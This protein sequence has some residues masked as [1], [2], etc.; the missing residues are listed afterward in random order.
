[1][2]DFNFFEP[3]IDKPSRGQSSNLVWLILFVVIFAVMGFLQFSYMTSKNALEDETATIREYTQSEMILNKVAVVNEKKA[4]RDVMGTV[5]NEL[6]LFDFLMYVKSRLHV[7][8]FN[9]ILSQVP[10][11]VFITSLNM[12]PTQVVIAG[13]SDSYDSVAVFQ[14][15]LRSLDRFSNVFVPSISENQG[16]YVFTM[17]STFTVEVPNANE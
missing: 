5:A 11:Y 2:A 6:N 14:H 1:M 9:D 12:T 7:G 17:T 8:L 15:Q 10:E 4:L 13:Y 16:N 3:Y